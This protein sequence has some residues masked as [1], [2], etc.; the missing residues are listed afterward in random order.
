MRFGGA[1]RD[2]PKPDS[3]L[4]RPRTAEL[5]NDPNNDT[6]CSNCSGAAQPSAPKANDTLL[7][8]ESRGR[9]GKMQ[10]G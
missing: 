10:F 7:F 4:E 5:P 9:G 3:V 1:L 2:W 8:L 6:N